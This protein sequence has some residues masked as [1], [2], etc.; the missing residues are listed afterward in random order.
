MQACRGGFFGVAAVASSEITQTFLK[1]GFLR[2]MPIL[3]RKPISLIGAIV[4]FA[5]LKDELP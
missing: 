5:L 3:Y 2:P 1:P 4:H